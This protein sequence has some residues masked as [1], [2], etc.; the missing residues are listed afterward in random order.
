VVEEE[1]QEE[2]ERPRSV[3]WRATGGHQQRQLQ[4][5]VLVL[6]HKGNYSPHAY[7][8]SSL[9]TTATPAPP[10]HPQSGASVLWYAPRRQSPA[11]PHQARASR[12]G[13]NPPARVC[14][15]VC[16]VPCVC[17]VLCA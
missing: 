9:R 12:G 13:D 16:G 17:R 5:R 1:Q 2:R 15:C 10:H 4:P 6:D 3:M 14:V 7:A 11:S 8:A